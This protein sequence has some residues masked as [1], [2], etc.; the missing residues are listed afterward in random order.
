MIITELRRQ[1]RSLYR[2][3]LD[4]A[5]GPLVDVRTFDDSPYRIGGAISEEELALLLAH[6][7]R[8]RA[9]DKGLYLLS[10]R[11]YGRVE[12]IRKLTPEYPRPV[13]EEAV[14][15][16][17]EER[18][19]DD[20]R[21]AFRLAERGRE[22]RHWSRGRIRQ[23]LMRRGIDRATADEA[24]AAL[25]DDEAEQALLLIEK[26]YRSKMDDREGRQKVMA[27][28][29]RRGFGYGTVKAAFA[30][31]DEERDEEPDGMPD[32]WD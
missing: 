3:M 9:Y 22:N 24:V 26:S 20:E 11:D 6:A 27:A 15:R 30:Q 17:C 18:L 14:E 28:L 2:L 25:P 7:E 5:E 21:Y 23:E 10:L 19:I 32:E 12:L 13:A 31:F 16:L 29:A 4:G 1:R 8:R